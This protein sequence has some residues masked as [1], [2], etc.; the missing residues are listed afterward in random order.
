MEHNWINHNDQFLYP[1]DLYKKDNEFKHD[2]LIFMLFHPKNAI[3]A[4]HGINH[5]IPFTAQEVDAK[6][7]FKSDFMSDY[8]KGRKLSKE[9]KETVKVGKELWKYYHSK[10]TETNNAVIDASFYDI[11]EYFQGR[12]KTKGAMNTKSTDEKYNSLNLELRQNLSLLTKK[13][14]PKI[15]EYGFLVE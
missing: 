6:D 7:N 15:Y 12:S 2:C 3:L 8:L 1:N 13:M 14:Q 4:K 9:A 5:W 11:R 10:I